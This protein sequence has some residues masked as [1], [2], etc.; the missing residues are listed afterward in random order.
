MAYEGGEQGGPELISETGDTASY[1]RKP[2][3]NHLGCI[4]SK[5]NTRWRNLS[6][7]KMSRVTSQELF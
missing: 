5:H 3:I 1:I 4:R 7:M 6:R 2:H